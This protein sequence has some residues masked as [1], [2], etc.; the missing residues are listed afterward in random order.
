[1]VVRAALRSLRRGG[2]LIDPEEPLP[3]PFEASGS[4]QDLGAF[5][6]REEFARTLEDVLRRRT[7]A[8]LA[9]DRGRGIARAVAGAMAAE[10]H[11]SAARTGQELAAWQE[12]LAAEEC[13]LEAAR[14]A[15]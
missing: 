13:D 1:D 8:W 4:H 11:W 9:P 5:A 10:L 14:E 6:V 3:A 15:G 7:R 12:S 2:A